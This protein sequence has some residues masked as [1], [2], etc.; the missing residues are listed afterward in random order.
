[1]CW[2]QQRK[3]F[4]S[5]TGKL[6]SNLA[7]YDRLE[8]N[9]KFLPNVMQIKYYGITFDSWKFS[10]YNVLTPEHCKLITFKLISTFFRPSISKLLHK[11]FMSYFRTRVFL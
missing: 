1:M 10:S 8:C 4:S 11:V 9:L 5:K 6:V 2:L 7:S 3:M